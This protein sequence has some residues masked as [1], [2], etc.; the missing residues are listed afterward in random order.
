MLLD[1]DRL[2]FL[3][4]TL[5]ST[6][7]ASP[8]PEIGSNNPGNL[9]YSNATTDS[10]GSQLANCQ[11]QD[12]S[13]PVLCSSLQNQSMAAPEFLWRVPGTNTILGVTPRIRPIPAPEARTAINGARRRVE[14]II[15][16][17][18]D[19]PLPRGTFTYPD[20]LSDV[21]LT[22]VT[23][24]NR[25]RWSEVRYALLGLVTVMY[26]RHLYREISFRIY[27]ESYGV[28]LRED[29]TGSIYSMHHDGVASV[30]VE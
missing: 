28:R 11:V 4:F 14:S 10:L 12:S 29:G 24:A 15:H 5:F 20:E 30:S 2:A 7:S 19:A 3:V 18:G 22:F 8:L 17:Q 6:A 21:S 1:I 23:Y 25:L 9:Q 26:E 27:D 13:D 16:L